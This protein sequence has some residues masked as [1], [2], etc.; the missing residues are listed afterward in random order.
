[1]TASAPS[2]ATEA[3][4]T[5]LTVSGFAEVQVPADRVRLRFA[6]ETQ[7]ESAADAASRNGDT[8]RSVLERVRS[9][10]G[11]DDRVET[12]GYRL[13]PRYRP[14]NDRDLGPEVVGYRAQNAVVVVLRDVDRVGDARTPSSW[15]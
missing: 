2:V 8:M 6:V 13:S 7:A 9:A 12:S 14:S 11:A 4:T 15:C 10:V 1:M 3:D 5:R